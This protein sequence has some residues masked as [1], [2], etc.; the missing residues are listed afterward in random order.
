ME[1]GYRQMA[2]E[3]DEL[4]GALADREAA[5][6]GYQQDLAAAEEASQVGGQG[7]WR[8]GGG[9]WLRSEV[10]AAP[11]TEEAV[12]Q[13]WTGHGPHHPPPGAV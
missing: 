6:Q 7:G 4:Q 11:G 10:W 1:Q 12:R 2:G 9:G 8:V 5:L 3:L 13:D